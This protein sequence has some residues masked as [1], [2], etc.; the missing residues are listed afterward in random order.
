MPTFT[1]NGT[2]YSFTPGSSVL[3]AA[4]QNGIRIPSLCHHPAL[5][6]A[7]ACR[8]CMVEI[9]GL[10]GFPTACTTPATEGMQVHTNTPA[11]QELRREVLSLILSE[12]PYTCLVCERHDRCNEWQVTIR[13]AAVTTGCENCPKNGQCEL[14]RLVEETGLSLMPYSIRYRGLPL[15]KDDPFFDRD[16]NLCIQCGRCVRLCAEERQIHALAFLQR[17][18]HTVVGAG[19]GNSLLD[20]D[21]EFCG[22]CVD[23][24]PTGALFDRRTKWEGVPE[25]SVR[26]VCPYCSVGCE[27]ELWVRGGKVTGV[28]PAADGAVNQGMACARGRFGLVEMIHAPERLT[29]PLVRKNGRL[30]PTG[31]DEALGTA[32]QWLTSRRGENFALLGS[33]HLPN[34]ALAALASFARQ[35]MATPWVDVPSALP[36]IPRQAELA[37]L[38]R[39]ERSAPLR[40]IREARTILVI[41]A[42]P[43][44]SHP[45]AALYIRQAQAAGAK[46]I[47]ID[48]RRSEL[49]QRADLWVRVEAG[50]DAEILSS[51]LSAHGPASMMDDL[52]AHSPAVILYGSGVTHYANAPETLAAIHALAKQ[53]KAGVIPLLGAANLR[54]ALASG[55]V[56]GLYT[57]ITAALACRQI[58]ALYVTGELPPLDELAHLEALIV[59]DQFLSP[60]AAQWA[61]VVFPAAGFA[62]AAGTLTNLE[63][64]DQSLAA[65]IRPPGAAQPDAWIF[66]ELAR[67]LG[68]ADRPYA[69]HPA[70]SQASHPS[71]SPSADRPITLLLERNA[72]SYRSSA[73]TGRV[74]GMARYKPDEKQLAL[75]PAD[76]ERLGLC[77]GDLA[78]VVS[79]Y[80]SDTFHVSLSADLPA[81]TAW[82]SINPAHGS[83]LFPGMLPEVKAYGVQVEKA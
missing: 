25:K 21:C 76:A 48:P 62:E 46:L 49:A 10:R 5:K 73:L 29:T 70:I 36:R 63:G 23:V 60:Q 13:K 74:Q 64:H 54:G 80:G 67:L 82:A 72:F 14:Q 9:E 39:A 41:G 11:V 68:P 3:E 81:N 79:A 4:R 2:P 37:D 35:T 19:V 1:L 52:R 6:P 20:T 53:L 44:L 47:V 78:R 26:T 77:A 51:W 30:V 61:H 22:A 16:F 18:L 32:A 31:W 66:S 59:Q 24:C 69:S 17:G 57:A 65:A 27:L 83:K 43:R 58:K 75:P 34:E 56:T 12:H 28:R 40:S 45:V 50:K 33:A 38:F 42:N 8:L 71:A 15:E 7:G 55:S